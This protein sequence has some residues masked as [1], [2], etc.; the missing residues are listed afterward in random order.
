V[1]GGVSEDR[2]AQES[3]GDYEH[4][5]VDV[6]PPIAT[7]TLDRPEVY[8][9]L[10]PA[11]VAELSD[12]LTALDTRDEVRAVVLT[13]GPTFFAAGADIRAMMDVSA[14]DLMASERAPRWLAVTQFTKPLIA[15]VN[16]YVL[17]GG[18]E[19]MLMCDVII[20]GDGA[21]FGQ[22][23][24]NL[25]ILGG[26][27]ATQRWPRTVGK[28]VAMEVNLL[29]EFIDARRAYRLGLV[30]RIVPSEATIRVAQDLARRVA[31][32]PPLAVKLIKQSVD[33]ALEVGLADGL[34]FERR[35]FHLLFATEDKREG[36]AAF[37]DKR[38]PNFEGR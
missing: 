14:V 29:G 22:P 3:R 10:S 11:L 13:G 15:A 34:V 36:M 38:D 8:N 20:A 7:V 33:R 28:Y 30:N 16:G 21:R 19:L 2:H 1:V 5:I 9:A 6:D 12:A 26:A 25:G 17:G 4:L 37:V 27:G 31:E 32:K 23:E 24:V 35:G 18:C